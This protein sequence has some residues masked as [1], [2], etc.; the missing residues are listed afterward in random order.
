MQKLNSPVIKK[1]TRPQSAFF[2]R[3]KVLVFLLLAFVA[4]TDMFVTNN[5][6]TSVVNVI[7]RVAHNEWWL[8]FLIVAEAIR[9]LGYIIAEKSSGFHAFLTELIDNFTKSNEKSMSAWTR[10]RLA[11]T[12]KVLLGLAIVS[13]L[14]SSHYHVPA[15]YAIFL[16]PHIIAVNTPIL[17]QVALYMVIGL[18]SLVLMFWG[19]TKGGIDVHF[20]G[21]IKTRF[22]DVLG[23]DSVVARVKETIVFLKNPDLIEEHGG[24]VPGGI[25]LWGPPGTGKTL[26]AEA[27]AGETGNPFVFVDPGAFKVMF[28][29]AGILKVKSLFRKLRK[30][31]LRH[32]G[33]VVFFDEADSLG[34]RGA[35]AGTPGSSFSP[36]PT[37]NFSACRGLSYLS[38]DSSF[39]LLREVYNENNFTDKTQGKQSIVNRV[40][41]PYPGGGNMDGTLQ[42]LLSEISGLAKPRGFFNKYV[43]RALGFA[44][45]PPPKYRILIVMASNLP[46]AL[47]EALLRPGRLDRIYKVGYP[48]KEGRVAT[49][50]GYFSKISNDLSDEEINKLSTMT[51]YATGATIKNLVNESLIHALGDNR[52]KVVWT[53]VLA[54]K[55]AKDLGPP[56]DVEYITRERHAV[57]I[58]EACHAVVAAR[59]RQHLDIDVATIEKGGN[60][61]GMVAS[62]PPEDRFTSWRSEYEADIMVALASLAG[63]RMFFG[64]DNSSGVAGDL[65]AATHVAALMEGYWGMGGTLLSHSSMKR[66]GMSGDTQPYSKDQRDE[67][68]PDRGVNAR[69]EQKLAT[70]YEKTESLLKENRSEVLS[71]AHALETVKTISGD[72]VH[73]IINGTPGPTVDGSLY[74]ASSTLSILEHYHAQAAAAHRNQ[75]NFSV[76]VPVLY[77]DPAF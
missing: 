76:P 16:L 75:D 4:Y 39:S 12:F 50:K 31:A 37:S 15:L 49:Y 46:E 34:S 19:S 24:Y 63:E 57:A 27:V 28:W 62:I 35:L 73:A 20:P 2:D 7:H 25:L 38:S 68:R 59:V 3:I 45:K 10:F 60:Y 26:L 41:F 9:Q 65:D 36:S 61:L 56:E 40:M 13:S 48:S 5:V 21:D 43:R 67:V 1:P 72:D 77:A 64:G 51:P 44:P 55:K 53:D 23:Q 70:L 17:V 29:G 47:D 58:H 52:T 6:G 11:R 42:S 66:L 18:G 54:A 14:I 33:V 69:I 32:G 71:V 22:S 74:A 30:L 8:T